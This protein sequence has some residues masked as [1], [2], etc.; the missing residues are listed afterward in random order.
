MSA[1]Q[2]QDSLGIFLNLAS[3]LDIDFNRF[4][5]SVIERAVKVTDS[6][7]GI[8]M[9]RSLPRLQEHDPLAQV[10]STF[11]LE[12]SWELVDY[13]KSNIGEITNQF[14]S[15][16]GG[17]SP[18]HLASFPA[19]LREKTLIESIVGSPSS[20]W[21]RLGSDE[22]WLGCIGLASETYPA[23]SW[24][25]VES[26]QRLL[27]FGTLALNRLILREQAKLQQMEI[28]LIGRSEAFL[29]FERKLKQ[30]ASHPRCTVLIRGERGS[31]KEL[32]AYAIHCF[33]NRRGKPFIPV[34]ASALAESL[35]ADELF[36]HEKNAFTGADRARKG[37]FLAA[38]GG[39]LFLDEVGDLPH[40]LQVS[41]LRVIE[42]GELQRIGRDFPIKVDVRL[43][44]ATNRDLN[45]LVADGYFRGDLYDRL[46]VIELV[47]PPLRQRREDIPLLVGHF[48]LKHCQEINRGSL[49]SEH[50]VCKLRGE[51]GKVLCAS[52]EF[53]RALQKHNW[54]GNV[55]EL[56]NLITRLIAMSPEEIL[57]INHL[58]KDL[59]K[60]AAGPRESS[61]PDCEDLSLDCTI[62]KH[63]ERVLFL[64][65]NCQTRAAKML[66]I[67]RTTLQ[68][69]MRR[70]RIRSLPASEHSER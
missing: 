61:G 70:L 47:V 7:V 35:H 32:A 15:N 39:T 36:G 34:L 1:D 29:E 18:F 19:H 27:S 21:L 30:A 49:I 51:S 5:A 64:T 62:K 69:K 44:V 67:P 41:L 63:I 52:E 48:L 10:S 13:R 60:A 54:P 45:K 58:P 11:P 2:N 12:G 57:N 59:L 8:L 53:Y 16:T 25:E 26:L 17:P 31:G 24:T 22:D 56:E 4:L 40:A 68:A 66:G 38:E 20:I 65:D 42:R 28:N 46:N 14:S 23:Y 6:G 55:R 43:L 9:F 50:C 33:S 3:S 37:K